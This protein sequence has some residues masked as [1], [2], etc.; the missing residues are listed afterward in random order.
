MAYQCDLGS[1]QKLYVE[2]RDAQTI[3][4]L[5]SSSAGQ[6]QSQQS[7][8]QTGEWQLP[9]TLFQ[10]ATGLIL[11]IESTQGHTFISLQANSI[12]LLKGL[13]SMMGADVLPL[14]KTAESVSSF[15]P[16]EPMKPM[17]PLQMNNMNLRS[18]P[19]EMRLGNMHMSMGTPTSN[20]STK[21]FC[22]QCGERVEVSDRFC[23]H[24]GT[25]LS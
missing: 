12:S 21:R 23:A 8:F 15:Q 17:E 9:P 22:S 4:A 2:N 14:Q 11:R 20:Q 6:Q 7:S 16:M 13:P 3:V 1:G 19:M 24:C 5:T 10:T 25:K 18:Q